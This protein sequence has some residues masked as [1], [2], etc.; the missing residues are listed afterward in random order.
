MTHFATSSHLPDGMHCQ[1]YHDSWKTGGLSVIALRYTQEYWK[2][3]YIYSSAMF[4]FEQPISK[5]SKNYWWERKEAIRK[6]VLSSVW[7]QY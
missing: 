2:V 4:S 3:E 1:I 5:Q 7:E 6:D